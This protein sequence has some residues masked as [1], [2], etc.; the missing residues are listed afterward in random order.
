M[1][2]APAPQPRRGVP[3]AG[4]CRRDGARG[5]SALRRGHPRRRCRAEP[6]RAPPARTAPRR[7][8]F[9]PRHR[10]HRAPPNRGAAPPRR[11]VPARA[12]PAVPRVVVPPRGAHLCAAAGGRAEP[13][14]S[15]EAGSGNVRPRAPPSCPCVRWRPPHVRAGR[16]GT[17]RHGT[18][19]N[20]TERHGSP[21]GPARHGTPRLGVTRPGL[22]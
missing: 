7:R 21:H 13:S 18:E 10:R 5:P 6:S 2:P 19:R 15:G 22:A 11:V 8:R 14:G 9:E 20:G 1:G 3:G 16:N 4:G 12:N 17:A